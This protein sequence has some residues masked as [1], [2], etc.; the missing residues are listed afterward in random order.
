MM[1]DMFLFYMTV[2][3]E[4]SPE[5]TDERPHKFIKLSPLSALVGSCKFSSMFMLPSYCLSHCRKKLVFLLK[6]ES[7]FLS[8]ALMHEWE[9]ELLTFYRSSTARF[10]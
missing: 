7:F 2:D 8:Y 5:S 10:A 1:E 6:S 3:S 4:S 9:S